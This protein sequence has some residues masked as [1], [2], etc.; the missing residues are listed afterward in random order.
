MSA[1]T[2]AT[3]ST[4]AGARFG[5]AAPTGAPEVLL[6]SRA[7]WAFHDGLVLAVRNVVK[8][9]RIPGLLVFGIIQP[10]MF[11]LLFAFVFG[12]AIAIPGGG[13]YR[14]YLVAGIFVQTIA[15]AG[16]ATS[17]GLSED[18]SKGLVDR[19]RSLPMARSAVL[20][21]RT[22][23]DLV[24]GSITVAVMSLTGLLIGWRINDGVLRAVLAYLLLLAFGYALSWIGCYI[25]LSVSSTE[26]AQ[27]AG[28]IWLF[29]LTFLSNAFVP[30]QGMPPWLQTIADWNPVS[31]VVA[32]LRTLF[33]NPN[34]FADGSSL[35]QQYPIAVALCWIAL[36]LL[37]FI[38]LSVR[39][40]R[41][42]ARR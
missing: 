2:H 21:G 11:I 18:M 31:A 26:V 32:S 34:P 35:P 27:T 13:S 5:G 28:F 14:E 23:G 40:Y 6:R 42:V 22:L 37:I 38:P 33:G 10:I 19:F 17:V 15:F 12:G 39:K 25:G 4:D 36:I 8:I 1:A 29:P 41:T 9:S 3:G 16:A 24:R 7:Y 30:T 20:V